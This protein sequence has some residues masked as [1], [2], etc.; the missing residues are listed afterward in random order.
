MSRD[1]TAAERGQQCIC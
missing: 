1:M